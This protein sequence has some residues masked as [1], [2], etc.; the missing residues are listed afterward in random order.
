[1]KAIDLDLQGHFV[2]FV[3]ELWKIQLFRVLTHHR[4]GLESLNLHQTCI[5]GLLSVILKMDVIDHEIQ[6]HFGHLD[7]GC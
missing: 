5:L 4:F 7:L 6:G 3:S 2:Y 1:M